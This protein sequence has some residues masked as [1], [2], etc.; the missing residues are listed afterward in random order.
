MRQLLRNGTFARLLG[1]R[2]V[3]NAGDSLYY[4]AAMWLVYDLAGSSFY[5]GLAGAAVLPTV[6]DALGGADAYGFLLAAITGGFLVGAL[7]AGAV[8]RYP[9]SRRCT[10]GFAASGGL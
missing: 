1:G 7:G 8:K 3:T 5:A 6:G 4:V 10:V 9:V 2:L